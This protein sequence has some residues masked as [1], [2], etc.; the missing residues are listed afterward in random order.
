MNLRL[1]RGPTLTRAFAFRSDFSA[2]E[3]KK[4]YFSFELFKKNFQV[5]GH[6]VKHMTKLLKYGSFAT[7]LY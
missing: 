4:K 2:K 7:L 1:V 3:Q 6:P 5:I